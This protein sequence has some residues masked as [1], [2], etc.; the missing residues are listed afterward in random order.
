MASDMNSA[1]SRSLLSLI[2]KD[3]RKVTTPAERKEAWTYHFNRDHW[4]FHGPK[5][6]YWNGAA[7]DGW[8]ARYCGWEAWMKK[9][10][11]EMEVA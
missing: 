11:P 8:H 9:H 2:M 1:F 5:D 6:F 10:H 4:E 3:V 7:G